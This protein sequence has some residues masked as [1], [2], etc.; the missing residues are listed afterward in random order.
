MISS[1]KYSHTV[2]VEDTAGMTQVFPVHQ[3]PESQSLYVEN[4]PLE[5]RLQYDAENDT[6]AILFTDESNQ[7]LIPL[8]E[9]AGKSPSHS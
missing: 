9:D 1:G 5:G 7:L 4:I 6:F 2:S 8:E 3:E